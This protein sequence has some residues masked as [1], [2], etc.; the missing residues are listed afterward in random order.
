M[1]PGDGLDTEMT[2]LLG[3]VVWCVSVTIGGL[4]VP[5]YFRNTYLCP[6]SSA[7]HRGGLSEHECYAERRMTMTLPKYL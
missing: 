5:G 2:S 3:C 7:V 4:L 1:R 6:S